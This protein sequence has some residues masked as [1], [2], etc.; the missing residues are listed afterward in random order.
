MDVNANGDG[1]HRLLDASQERYDIACTLRVILSAIIGCLKRQP[2][3]LYRRTGHQVILVP[4]FIRP[5][6][7][8]QGRPTCAA[9]R[10]DHWLSLARGN[11]CLIINNA[12]MYC[13]N[14]PRRVQARSSVRVLNQTGRPTGSRCTALQIRLTPFA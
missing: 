13:N 7:D 11:G 1:W 3:N 6:I 8:E 5:C 12:A 10:P 2:V 14:S 4:F 9:G